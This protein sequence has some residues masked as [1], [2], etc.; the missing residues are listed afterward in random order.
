MRRRPASRAIV[1]LVWAGLA[2]AHSPARARAQVDPS[3]LTADT[4]GHAV[5]L[6]LLAGMNGQNSG[7]NFNGFANGGLT[8]KVPAGWRIITEFRNKDRGQNHGFDLVKFAQPVPA[9]YGPLAAPEA[10]TDTLNAGLAPG[11][12]KTVSFAAPP[13]GRY[14]VRCTA[15]GHATL[16]M[17]IVLEVDNALTAPAIAITKGK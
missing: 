9:A 4:A 2:L 16:G 1:A 11:K 7:M 10:F 13:P 8:V 15:G 6:Q 14:I 3:W 5:T 12:A 17:W